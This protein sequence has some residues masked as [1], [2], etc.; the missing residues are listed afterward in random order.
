MFLPSKCDSF[1][2]HLP[3]YLV[4]TIDEYEDSNDSNGNCEVDVDV[5]D[6][7]NVD[8]DK[9]EDGDEDTDDDSTAPMITAEITTMKSVY[10]LMIQND[11]HFRVILC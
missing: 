11:E 8:N 6:E 2:R 5:D 10:V 1:S 3:Q 9:D 4:S 7:D